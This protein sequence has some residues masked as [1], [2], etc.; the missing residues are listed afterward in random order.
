VDFRWK[1]R[2]AVNLFAG[3]SGAA[4]RGRLV[5]RVGVCENERFVSSVGRDL[6]EQCSAW[7]GVP[8]HYENTAGSVG[9]GH[10]GNQEA[11]NMPSAS[12]KRVASG[13]G[14]YLFSKM[15]DANPGDESVKSDSPKNTQQ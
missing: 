13:Q 7:P 5:T 3:D 6:A 4:L 1:K 12:P 8:G 9:L 10:G 15:A 11:R 2:R 14:I